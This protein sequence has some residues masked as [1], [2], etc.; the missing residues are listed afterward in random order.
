VDVRSWWNG[1]TG[2]VRV[3]E[4]VLMISGEERLMPAALADAADG[5]AALARCRPLAMLLLNSSSRPWRELAA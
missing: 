2:G 1:D 5:P 3:L 4:T